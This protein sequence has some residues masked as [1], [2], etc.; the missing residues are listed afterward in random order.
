[1]T[2]ELAQVT[3]RLEAGGRVVIV[4]GE[5]DVSN[6]GEV[7]DLIGATIARED[8]AVVIDLTDIQYLDSSAIRLLFRLAERLKRN[9]QNLAFAVGE[10]GAARKILDIA[11]ISGQ[12]P[13]RPDASAA[14]V[15][16]AAAT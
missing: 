7:Y 5:V 4:R 16:L 14:L 10:S 6:A 8:T 11:G 9:R 2:Q 15:A 3:G 12:Y 13:C 1:M